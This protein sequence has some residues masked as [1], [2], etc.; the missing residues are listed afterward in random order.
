MPTNIPKQRWTFTRPTPLGDTRSTYEIGADALRFESDDLFDGGSEILAWDTILEGATAAMAGMGGRGGP[1]FAHWVPAHL[2]WLLLSR[3]GTGGKAFM[4]VLPQG[5]D[6]DAIVR[7]VQERLGSRWIGEGLPLTDA[8]AR[9]KIT[10]P[11]FGT[12]KVVGIIVS[13]LALLV[14]LIMVLGLLLRPAITVPVGFVAGGWLLRRGLAGLKEGKGLANAPS[15]KVASVKPGLVKL[16]GRAVT[17]DPV[18]GGI[19]GQPCVWWD[20]A[21]NLWY[22]GD[23]DDSGEWRQVAARYGGTVDIVN[24]EDD[25]GQVPV[26]LKGAQLLLKAQSWQSQKDVLPARGMA[27]LDEL[28]FAWNGTRNISVTE[29]YLEANAPLYVLGTLDQRSDL[30]QPGQESGL[31][32]LEQMLRTGEWRRAL[33]RATPGVARYSVAVLIG[34]L[35]MMIKMGRGGERVKTADGSEPPVLAPA[36][37]IIWKGRG[38]RPFLVSNQPEQAALAAWNRRS[39][40]L[41]GVGLAVWCFTLYE[42]FDMLFGR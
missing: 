19:T 14:M 7:A 4:R 17:G 37:P 42:I 36:A 3:S 5:P 35:D 38:G 2:E 1:E 10:P 24:F 12:L 34:Y 22:E 30:P 8:Q 31:E 15:G 9:M 33:V 18:P 20:V 27:L 16:E 11:D 23:D 21:I 6:R 41:C 13:V 25:S 26:W 29:Q 32:R 40:V 39:Q 28:G